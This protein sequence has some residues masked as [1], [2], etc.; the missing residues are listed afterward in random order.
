VKFTVTLALRVCSHD[1]I[2]MRHQ[3]Y[4]TGSACCQHAAQLATNLVPVVRALHA[5]HHMV[6]SGLA[7]A[8]QGPL[9]LRRAVLV[10]DLYS[11][12]STFALPTVVMLQL[13][14]AQ[15]LEYGL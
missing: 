11:R 3:C 10:H 1:A 9:P 14:A 2:M 6:P 8:R 15:A 12:C 13:Y 7:W 4:G 5:Y